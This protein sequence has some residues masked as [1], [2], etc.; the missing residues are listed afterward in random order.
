[1]V[2]A[3]RVEVL[4]LIGGEAPTLPLA[5]GAA[6][7]AAVLERGGLAP[8]AL[9]EEGRGGLVPARGGLVVPLEGAGGVLPL[10][11]AVLVRGGLTDVLGVGG[12]VPLGLTVL[13]RGG[14]TDVLGVGGVLPLALAVLVRG[15]LT[16][17]PG[18]GGVVPLG[19]TVLVRGGL[20]DALGVGGVLPR[21]LVPAV[22]GGLLLGV[23]ARGVL[24]RG[25]L[26]VRA[27]VTTGSSF[28][29][30]GGGVLPLALE[31]DEGGVA[32][33]L[34]AVVEA[35]GGVLPR[36]GVVDTEANPLPILEVRGV[37]D[38]AAGT[39]GGLKIEEVT[40]AG[41]VVPIRTEVR[42]ITS[43]SAGG[44][45]SSP[46]SSPPVGMSSPSGRDALLVLLEGELLLEEEREAPTEALREG[47]L[48]LLPILVS[49]GRNSSRPRSAI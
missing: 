22:S 8:V 15:G 9:V 39:T 21:A 14:L 43:T 23:V 36:A 26:A 5:G 30:G 17:V 37:A 31:V 49:V 29:P 46:M 19:L 4:D 7:L 42:G 6:G 28:F 2:L 11:L 18:V 13:V 16:D 1:M 35:G 24:L 44:L 34:L 12:V 47:L 40:G 32:V 10:A 20:T 38:P 33:P 3:G 45:G 41:G 25:G 27:G 48:V